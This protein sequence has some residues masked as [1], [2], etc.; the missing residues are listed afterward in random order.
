[1]YLKLNTVRGVIVSPEDLH[2]IRKYP[3]NCT[4]GRVQTVIDGK[5]VRL[6]TLICK[7]DRVD[8]INGDGLDN[9]REN[10]RPCNASTNMQNSKIRI[11]NRSGYRGVGLHKATGKW[12]ARIKTPSGEVGLG[13]FN[14]KEAAAL[15]YNAAA[16][17]YFGEFANLNEVTSP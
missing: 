11:D 1:M 4:E 10:L 17:K 5:A 9:R 12:R 7:A 8:H 15:A 6:H 2:L 13:Y 14:T 3:W 16:K